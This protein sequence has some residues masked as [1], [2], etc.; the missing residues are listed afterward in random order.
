MGKS[1]H[2]QING[3][4]MFHTRLNVVPAAGDPRAVVERAITELRKLRDDKLASKDTAWAMF[5]RDEHPRF[6]EARI[7]AR[8]NG[9]SMA[10]SNPCFEL[11]GIF[12]YR[13]Y[14][15]PL[16]R[17]ECQRQLSRI[18]STYVA[19]RGKL[20]D[21]PEITRDRYADARQRAGTSLVDS[22]SGWP[23]ARL[24][25]CCAP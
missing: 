12:H 2:K 18:C 24:W 6:D 17:H 3:L 20:F 16:D 21:D 4:R 13:D 8:D 15:A 9:I 7:M 23:Q 22:P 14:D 5:D 1:G 19:D 10:I 25:R 11:W